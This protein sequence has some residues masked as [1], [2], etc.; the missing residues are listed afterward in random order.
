MAGPP[1]ETIVIHGRPPVSIRLLPIFVT[2][3][4]HLS[5]RS[6]EAA[7][8]LRT[9][10]MGAKRR[11]NLTRATKQFL[12][13]WNGAHDAIACDALVEDEGHPLGWVFRR[14]AAIARVRSGS[15]TGS[16]AAHSTAQWSRAPNAS[17]RGD[18]WK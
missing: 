17:A 3:R 14:S 2:S 13:G 11:F 1:A 8:L 16:P 18:G 5:V 12:S 10:W 9:T 7:E 15:K 4:A 6:E